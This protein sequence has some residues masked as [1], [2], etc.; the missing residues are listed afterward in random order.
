MH[1]VEDR[2]GLRQ[3]DVRRHLPSGAQ[4]AVAVHQ[5]Q[6]GA[7]DTIRAVRLTFGVSQQREGD[8]QGRTG[9]E[10]AQCRGLIADD[11]RGLPAQR[12]ES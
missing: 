5:Q 11:Q 10:I 7:L 8:R 2:V 12:R 9:V 3:D 1:G 6:A 4:D